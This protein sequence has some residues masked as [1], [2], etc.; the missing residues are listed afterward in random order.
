MSPDDATLERNKIIEQTCSADEADAVPAKTGKR[1]FLRAREAGV[2][3][4][5]FAGLEKGFDLPPDH[6]VADIASASVPHD[7]P[8]DPPVAH[9]AARLASESDR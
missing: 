5:G 4:G 2:I 7:P 6:G 1:K 8:H 3:S 9:A